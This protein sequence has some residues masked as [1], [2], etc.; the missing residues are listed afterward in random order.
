M[1]KIETFNLDISPLSSSPRKIWVYLPNGYDKSNKKYDVLY[2]FDGHNLF[3]DDVATYGKAWGIKEY[4]DN[5]NIDLV[6]VGQE[7]NHEG[8]KRMDEYCPLEARQTRWLKEPIK[9]EGDITAEWFVKVLKPTCEK[10]YRIYK[11]RRHV[12][13]AGSSMGGLMSAYVIAKYNNV[14]SKA[15]IVS[16]AIY[17]C[18]KPLIELIR[19]TEFKDTK[20]YLDYGSDEFRNKQRLA[21]AMDSL[22]QL[23]YEY[24][25]KGC[26][27]FP[28]IVVNG[29][30]S[31]ASWETIVPLFIEYLY[32]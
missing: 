21:T 14:F 12:G 28:N 25:K 18:E 1:G 9:P 30:H 17:F 27:T 16:P 8:E 31:E 20:I 5:N 3:Y 23:N 15:A 10:K 32:L 29:T 4:L 6:V 19:Q 26:N 24:A 11:D 22:L 13:I 2:M 7:C